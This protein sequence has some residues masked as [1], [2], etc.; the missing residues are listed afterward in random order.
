MP[1]VRACEGGH[2]SQPREAEADA[3]VEAGTSGGVEAE[4][5]AARGEQ[6]RGAS[7]CVGTAHQK[8]ENG[9]WAVC[10]RTGATSPS[11]AGGSAAGVSPREATAS[12]AT[13]TAVCAATP[14]SAAAAS[15]SSRAATA[16]GCGE[17]ARPGVLS[18]AAAACANLLRPAARRRSV[19][20]RNRPFLRRH[21]R[22][23][24]PTSHQPQH[25][26]RIRLLR[27]S[28]RR[29]SCERER[30]PSRT[31]RRQRRP[32]RWQGAWWTG[33]LQRSQA[34]GGSH[35]HQLL[36]ARGDRDSHRIPRSGTGPAC[37]EAQIKI[38]GL[39]QGVAGTLPRMG[40][41][42][43]RGPCGAG[44]AGL[45]R[46]HRKAHGPGLGQETVG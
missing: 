38:R 39:A 21:S 10:R 37:A 20:P 11:T 13:A 33:R 40:F 8:A 18:N 22:V 5:S 42:F 36:H 26:G 25:K 44:I 16:A 7:S 6:C 28:P 35:A 27:G 41:Q 24:S 43:S 32:L 1:G 2:P 19:K 12:A 34:P 3:G 46:G 23:C 9:E 30:H 31:G 15:S 45:L 17:A 29:P 4:G 14:A